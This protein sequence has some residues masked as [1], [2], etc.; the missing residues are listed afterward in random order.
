[1]FGTGHAVFVPMRCPVLTEAAYKD[2]RQLLG[3]VAP[4]PSLSDLSSGTH[5]RSCYA[6]SGTVLARCTRYKPLAC[7]I[8]GTDVVVP[9]PGAAVADAATVPGQYQAVSS[10]DVVPYAGT[11]RR[12]GQGTAADV[13]ADNVA[14]AAG[15]MAA[16]LRA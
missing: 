14:R 12:R 16:G 6:M 9:V 7:P 4:P 3:S 11:R 2:L 13:S 15:S 8:P 10:T 5:L 1:M